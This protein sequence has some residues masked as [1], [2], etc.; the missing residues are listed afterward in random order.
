M[1]YVKVLANIA[2]LCALLMS[3]ALLH[4][5]S[6]SAALVGL[7]A[8][9]WFVAILAACV[10]HWTRRSA[11]LLSAAPGQLLAGAQRAQ[12]QQAAQQHEQRLHV[13]RR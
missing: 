6:G 8:I 12:P 9:V 3:V 11:R 13:D 5:S 2:G 4:M 7:V 10:R 1:F